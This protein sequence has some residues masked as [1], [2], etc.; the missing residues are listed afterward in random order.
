MRTLSKVYDMNEPPRA[1]GERERSGEAFG[2]LNDL[3][4]D[5]ET[6]I[7]LISAPPSFLDEV[8]ASC[9]DENGNWIYEGATSTS[10]DPQD[11]LST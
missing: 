1:A 7:P 2:A 6:G 5:E 3:R 4:W 10:P 9:L 8:F 11:D